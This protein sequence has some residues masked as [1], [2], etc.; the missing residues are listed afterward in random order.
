MDNRYRCRSIASLKAEMN[1][2]PIQCKSEFPL[3]IKTYDIDI[4]GHVNNIAYIRW[5]EDMRTALFNNYFNLQELIASKIY[6]IVLS[7]ECKYR[8][9]L[10]LF[11]TPVGSICIESCIHGIF[12]LKAN[13]KNKGK[14]IAL[15]KQQCALFDLDELEIVKGLRLQEV[16]QD[17]HRTAASASNELQSKHSYTEK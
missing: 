1:N 11:D 15:G 6:P 3:E 8:K 12:T 10:V 16:L 7:T 14:T 5:L 4:A 13:I 2:F 17:H 9:Y